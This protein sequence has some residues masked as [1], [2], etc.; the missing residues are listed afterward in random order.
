MAHLTVENLSC[1]RGGNDIFHNLSFK[2]KKGESMLVRG[3][4][5]SG[6]TSLLRIIA[7]YL[8][9]VSGTCSFIDD[10]VSIKNLFIGQKNAIKNNLSIKNNIKLWE[11]LF[12]L[13][14]DYTDLL[15][16]VGLNCEIESDVASLSDGQKRRLS[17]L[18][19]FMNDS[20][21]WLLDET[22]VHLDEEWAHVLDQFILDHT[23]KG[24]VVIVTSNINLTLSTSLKIN[25]SDYN[26]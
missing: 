2:M 23:D 14:V 19:L 22:Y 26:V 24:G 1:S 21:L 15:S 5:G 11:L 8:D 13:K 9:P 4:N 25:L 16:S 18:R 3:A 17:L 12:D 10:G 6:K 7:G 20:L